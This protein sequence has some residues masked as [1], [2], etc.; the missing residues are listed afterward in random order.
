MSNCSIRRTAGCC[1]LLR[2]AAGCSWQLVALV[3][4]G[5][6]TVG[7]RVRGAMVRWGVALRPAPETVP[8][9][10]GDAARRT[11]P[12]L[13]SEAAMRV[14]WD[15]LLVAQPP[16]PADVVFV[17]GSQDLSMPDR[18]A[19]LY[20]AGHAPAVLAT[21]GFG[22]MT[23]G[24]FDQPEALVFRDR[25]IEAGVPA[26]AIVAET[27]AGNTLENVRFG[28]AALRRAGR[29]VGSALLVAKGFVTR[30]AVATFAAQAP[31]VRVRACPPTPRLSEAM[32]RPAEAFAARLVAELDRL[33]RYGARG[34]IARQRIPPAVRAAARQIREPGGGAPSRPRPRDPA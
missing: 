20:H 4:A 33:D 14:L 29:P 22:R 1:G 34:D 23:R 18:A 27:A 28:L 16:V 9:P 15:Y 3:A 21:G 11:R 13:R 5:E 10:T 7:G 26:A 30:R 17:F 2:A 25:L 32:D 19:E 12:A 31:E 6:R 24:V 8:R